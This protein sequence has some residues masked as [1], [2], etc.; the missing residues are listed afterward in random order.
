MYILVINCGSTST[1]MGLFEDET[2]ICEHTE[3][4]D[5]DS[6]PET[7]EGDL[8]M[9]R[10]SVKKFLESC[11]VGEQD[12]SCIAC[13]GG[14]FYPVHGGAYV[15]NQELVS[16]LKETSKNNPDN[17]SGI[18]GFSLSQELSI[19]A[20]I[21]DAVTVDEL[22]PIA[23]Y[24]GVKG[25][26]RYSRTHTLNT[27]AMAIAAAKELGRDYLDMN[28]IT[29]HLGGGVSVNVYEHGRL[30]D[31]VTSEEGGFSAERCGGLAGDT[32]LE[33]FKTRGY[34]EV[35][36]L[37]HG[38]GGL[39]SYFDSN[40]ALVV[41]EKIKG[42]DQEAEAIFEAMAY[43]VAKSI[44]AMAVAV[45]GKVDLIVLTGGIMRSERLQKWISE[46][47]SF[48]APVVVKAGE[49]EL[50]ALAGGALRVMRHEE[51]ARIYCKN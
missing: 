45:G 27:R 34:E 32:V 21:Y 36:R 43:Q 1:K 10:Q 8:S 35:E 5:I 40:D 39:V 15:V 4:Y 16:A 28:I 19:P 9:R 7:M 30:S 42:G 47:V 29:A 33:L 22:K 23:R 12:L 25:A 48:L 49:M 41:E 11:P 31:L 2:M 3:R 50:Q 14:A 18:I 38:K 51:E 37:F 13:R 6:L 20:Y 24:S 26:D 17:Y 44:G 46:R